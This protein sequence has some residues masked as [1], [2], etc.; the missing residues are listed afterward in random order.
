MIGRNTLTR[1]YLPLLALAVLLLAAACTPPELRDPK[2]LRD[3][4]LITDD[5]CAAPCWRGI[6]PGETKWTDALPL[7]QD[8]PAFADV[9]VQQGQDGA[10]GAQWRFGADNP[11]CCQ[12][13]S[14]TGDTVDFITVQLAPGVTVGQLIEA[15]GEPTYVLGR[16]FTPDQA[17]M[18]LLYPEQQLI[19]YAFVAGTANGVLSESSEVVSVSYLKPADMDLVISTN[20]LYTWNG[21]GAYTDTIDGTFDVTASVTLT[22]TPGQ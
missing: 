12:M 1:I 20:D 13:I 9:Q 4:S 6:T 15:K 2:M 16:D 3:D 19:V 11:P 21:Y 17:V 10:L 14:G 5:P 18:L 22:P 7:I 8:D